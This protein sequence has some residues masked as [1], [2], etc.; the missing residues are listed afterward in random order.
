LQKRIFPSFFFTFHS[1]SK[2]EQG[3]LSLGMKKKKEKYRFQE[4]EV[5]HEAHQE[6]DA[7]APNIC[8]GVHLLSTRL[9]GRHVTRRAHNQTGLRGGFVGVA[10]AFS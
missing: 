8:A 2:K 5:H 7:E 9:F 4:K 1:P 3:A 6:H 10:R